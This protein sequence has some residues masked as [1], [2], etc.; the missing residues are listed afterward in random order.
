MFLQNSD[1]KQVNVFQAGTQFKMS[2]SQ[3]MTILMS[4]EPSYVRCIKPNDY[5]NKGKT[6][7]KHKLR[8]LNLL[9]S[10]KLS[11]AQVEDESRYLLRNGFLHFTLD[12][13][14]LTYDVTKKIS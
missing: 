4:K 2:L 6:E 12:I 1:F 8:K 7:H 11:V 5:K 13:Y 3:L 14:I 9:K 10:I